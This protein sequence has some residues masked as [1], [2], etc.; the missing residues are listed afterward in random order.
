MPAIQPVLGHKTI[1]SYFSLAPNATKRK[2]NPETANSASAT[3]TKRRKQTVINSDVQGSTARGKEEDRGTHRHLKGVEN[4][5]K[6]IASTRDVDWPYIPLS[7][8]PP[9]TGMGITP[10][11]PP[12]T[13]VGPSR[14]RITSDNERKLQ[15]PGPSTVPDNA[16]TPFLVPPGTPPRR[17]SMPSRIDGAIRRL[18]KPCANFASSL[19]NGLEFQ[20]E[21]EHEGKNVDFTIPSSQ[22]QD[23]GVPELV[24]DF[25]LPL[26]VRNFQSTCRTQGEEDVVINSSQSQLLTLVSPGKRGKELRYQATQV[27]L[28]FIPSSQ[29]QERELSIPFICRNDAGHQQVDTANR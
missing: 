22:S 27:T 15:S 12:T 21:G 11:T 4:G 17:H 13:V 7:N 5:S 16:T 26:G 10:L 8:V 28:D 24:V 20:H 3:G 9:K 18:N 6:N 1:T 25:P 29:S 19:R 2:Y 23:I 14:H